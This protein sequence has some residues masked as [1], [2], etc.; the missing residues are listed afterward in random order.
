[1]DK[2]FTK[3]AISSVVEDSLLMQSLNSSV[4]QWAGLALRWILLGQSAGVVYISLA[5]HSR[6]GAPGLPLQR[7]GALRT[8]QKGYAYLSPHPSEHLA[9]LL[10][11]QMDQRVKALPAKP[12][13][14]IPRT[15]RVC[16]GANR[17]ASCPL[18]SVHKL[19]CVP[20]FPF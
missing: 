13:N 3:L 17:P 18:T 15:Y 5:Q 9:L 14:S 7:L 16:V 20:L 6:L 11:M 19:W 4:W 8:R 10:S 1:M 12:D 2:H